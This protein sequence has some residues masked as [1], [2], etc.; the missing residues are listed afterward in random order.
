MNE[1]IKDKEP[2]LAKISKSNDKPIIT[3]DTSIK[4]MLKYDSEGLLLAFDTSPEKFIQLPV[5]VMKELSFDN[6]LRY[7]QAKEIAKLEAGEEKEDW[8]DRVVVTEQ[9]ASAR[10]RTTVKDGDPNFDYYVAST[11]K[12]GKHERKGYHV[13]PASDP[14]SIGVS[15]R[16]TIGTLGKDELVLM[17][18][19][20][21]NKAKLDK[22][23]KAERLRRKGAMEAGVKEL[24]E[25]LG[26]DVRDLN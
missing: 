4:D 25:S 6:K 14:A 11:G 21:E 12:I 1:E 24:G 2:K 5:E 15:G 20:K 10:D 18:T 17:R 23:K 13:A 22:I 16:K 26:M 8:K 3:V 9:Y 19:P 7:Q